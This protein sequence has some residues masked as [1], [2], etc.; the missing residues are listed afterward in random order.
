MDDDD[1]NSSSD[2]DAGFHNRDEEMAEAGDERPERAER[3]DRGERFGRERRPRREERGGRDQSA[4]DGG[5]VN[6]DG[7]TIP[8][9]VLPPAIGRDSDD[10]A[11]ASTR[12]R[13][14]RAAGPALRAPMTARRLRPPR[15]AR[16]PDAGGCSRP[17]Q[18]R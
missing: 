4:G 5:Q 18:R 15:P 1:D 14:G 2:N 3:Q 17:A 10:T 11:E 7:E 12:S 6:G 8:F 9:D 16:R 13:A